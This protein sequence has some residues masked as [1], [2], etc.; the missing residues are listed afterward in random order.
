MRPLP[1]VA[2]D[3]GSWHSVAVHRDCHVQHA[4]VLYSV[5]F[6]LVGKRLWLRANDSCVAIYEDYR[7]VTTH[8]RGRKPGARYTILAHLPP[9][10]QA[11]FARDRNW[12]SSQA[13]AIGPACAELIEQL[14]ADRIVERLRAAQGVLRLAERYGATRLEAACTRALVHASPF[15]RTVKT[16]LVNGYDQQPLPTIA[17]QSYA[18]NARFA[19]ESASLFHPEREPLIN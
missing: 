14:L 12:C 9:A 4:R 16:I 11:F 19:R 6:T 8:A 17:A 13:A 18:G 10:A 5:P 2:P 15:Y 7:L 1:N 3:L